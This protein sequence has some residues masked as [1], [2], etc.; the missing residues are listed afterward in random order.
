MGGRPI[1]LLEWVVPLVP[2]VPERLGCGIEAE[3]H[4]T[5]EDVDGATLVRLADV[6]FGNELP[7]ATVHKVDCPG[8]ELFVGQHLVDAELLV[9]PLLDEEVESIPVEEVYH[10]SV[11]CE[12]DQGHRP[13]CRSLDVLCCGVDDTTRAVVPKRDAQHVRTLSG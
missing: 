8:V 7:V 5:Y 3:S 11:V 12:V 6:R 13:W 9:T 1:I 10:N 2:G 4:G